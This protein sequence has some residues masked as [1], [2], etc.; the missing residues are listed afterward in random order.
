[1]ALD[2]IDAASL[3]AC[4]RLIWEARGP[5]QFAVGSQ[6]VEYALVALLAGGG[7]DP[8]AAGGR[9]ASARPERMAVV[10]G[11]VSPVTAAQIDW[12][13]AHGFEGIA[14]DARAVVDPRALAEAEAA[15]VAAALD[16]VGRGR[17]PLIFTARGPDDPGGAGAARGAAP[18][19]GWRRRRRTCGSARRSGGCSTR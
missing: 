8:G 1:M 3:A 7:A 12:S 15:A 2:C 14:F 6:G 13:L 9:R 16:A 11:S 18:R 17:D 4:G 10:S 5:Q 19:P